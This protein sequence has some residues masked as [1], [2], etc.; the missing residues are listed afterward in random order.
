MLKNRVCMPSVMDAWLK[1]KLPQKNSAQ[2]FSTALAHEQW[3]RFCA[4]VAYAQSNSHFYANTLKNIHIPSLVQT[5]LEDIPFTTAQDLHQW[6]Q[7]ICISL[8]D[9]ERMVSLQTSGTTG[10]SK[11][12]AF[13][14]QDLQATEDFFAIG[15]S[16]LVQTHDRVLALWPGA[17][18][19]QG[20]SALL[21]EALAKNHIEVF[22]GNPATTQQSLWAELQRYNPHAVVGAPS[23][24]EVLATL[25]ENPYYKNELEKNPLALRCLLSSGEN[26]H[27][28]LAQRW[29]ELGLQTLDHYGITEAGYSIGVQ[30]PA[31]NGYHL[32]ELDLFIE[33]IEIQGTK[34][35]ADGEEGEVV[36]TTLGRTAM[37]LIRY[38]TGDIAAIIATPCP[39]GSPLRRLSSLRGRLIAQGNNYT[40]EK[41]TKGYLHERSTQTTL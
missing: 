23:Q 35:L 32:R 10:F 11:R 19:P 37:P 12:I 33:I 14:E 39:C 26:V 15:M 41:C 28:S 25:L 13:S 9:I 34:P 38:R 27:P 8:G 30:C 16:Q 40:I 5:N 24:L 1:D 29:Q 31:K 4:I 36:I 3:Q 18:L 21:R 20:V 6:E 22:D 2:D 17:H 7:F